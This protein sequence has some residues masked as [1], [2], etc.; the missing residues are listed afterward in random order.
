MNKK[1]ILLLCALAMQITP[2]AAH[3]Y[4]GPGAAISLLGSIL[5]FSS[6]VLFGAFC[7][8]AW[9]IWLVIRVIKRK[10]SANVITKTDADQQ[11]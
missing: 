11:H 9:P 3:A 6:M 8:I 4:I 5:G 1:N 7:T 10:R 2:S